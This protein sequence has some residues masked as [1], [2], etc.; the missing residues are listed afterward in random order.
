M[1]EPNGKVDRDALLCALVLAPTTFARNRF[2]ALYTEPWARRTRS[3]AAQIRAIV[4]QLAALTP[5]PEFR[6]LLPLEE[7]GAVIRYGVPDLHF[8]RTAILDPLELSLVRFALSR[9]PRPAAH[10]GAAN[11]RP[12]PGDAMTVTDE[13]RQSVERA[14]AKLGEKLGLESTMLEPPPSTG[15]S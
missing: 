15:D 13:D 11:G 6:E 12:P 3:R 14:L 10:E 7:G 2:F 5:K 1:S 8:E 4:R 9:R